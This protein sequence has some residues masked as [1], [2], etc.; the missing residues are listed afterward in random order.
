MIV[1][2]R[3]FQSKEYS[4]VKRRGLRGLGAGNSVN[5]TTMWT[6]NAGFFATPG[7]V[8]T[9]ANFTPASTSLLGAPKCSSSAE[10]FTDECI[11]VLLANQQHDMGVNNLNNYNVFLAN[12]LNSFP[13]P[14]D[15]YQRTFGLTPV[16]GYTGSFVA[17][18]PIGVDTQK[19]I[20]GFASTDKAISNI[21]SDAKIPSQ[22]Q[23][24]Q[25]KQ[26]SQAASKVGSGN[27]TIGGK[28]ISSLTD[29]LTGDVSILGMDIPIW[30]LGLAAAGVL[31]VVG[32][33]GN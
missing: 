27:I 7:K 15:C 12:C 8:E 2:N 30:A 32:R 10:M 17:D 25:T 26:Q 13:Q 20:T 24:E 33:G 18:T 4:Q 21:H 22:S 14:K 29:S 31:F 28:D 1:D 6:P 16:G 3:N 23:Q 11:Q 19:F 9:A 5:A